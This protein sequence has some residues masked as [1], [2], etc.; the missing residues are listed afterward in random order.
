M[1]LQLRA[2]EVHTVLQMFVLQLLHQDEFHIIYE[3]CTTKL[4]S[5][6]WNI[7]WDFHPISR[8]K[9]KSSASCAM[10]CVTPFLCQCQH[11]CTTYG[12][13]QTHSQLTSQARSAIA[14]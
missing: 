1:P 8:I 2:V 11:L 13:R 7:C 4:A 5:L 3:R 14:A 12:T 9:I 6:F 10:N